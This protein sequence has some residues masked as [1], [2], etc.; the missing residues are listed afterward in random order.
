MILKIKSPPGAKPPVQERPKEERNGKKTFTQCEDRCPGDPWAYCIVLWCACAMSLISSGYSLYKQQGLQD[1]LSLLEE[2]HFALRSAVLE[3]Q[4]PLVERLRREVLARPPP[5]YW[6]PRRS[7]RDYGDCVCPPVIRPIL[8]CFGLNDD[9]IIVKHYSNEE[10]NEPCPWVF[11]LHSYVAV[12]TLSLPQL[13]A[14]RKND[15]RGAGWLQSGSVA[16]CRTRLT[17]TSIDARAQ[18]EL[19]ARRGSVLRRKF[20]NEKLERMAGVNV[21]L[22]TKYRTMTMTTCATVG[23]QNKNKLGITNQWRRCARSPTC[24]VLRLF[25]PKIYV[26]CYASRRAVVA[27]WSEK[28][29][30]ASFA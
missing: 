1:R 4:Q 18:S 13:G 7:I 25:P 14:D 23:H 6:R 17:P 26:Y 30:S 8:F 20:T 16:Y 11:S 27:A 19:C 2:Q 15:K 12:G 22:S 28:P 29:D 21:T 3:P 24:F 10:I 5:S 9:Y